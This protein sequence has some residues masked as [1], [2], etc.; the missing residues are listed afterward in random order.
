MQ[1]A[2]PVSRVSSFLPVLTATLV[3]WVVVVWA[4]GRG[5]DFTDDAHYLIWAAN[6]FIY[7]WSVSEFGFLLHPIYRLVEGDI[8]LFRLAG[9][10]LLG[11]GAAVFGYALY[12]FA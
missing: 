12:R 4:M 3:C 6:P 7:D 5:Y 11:G 8:W 1:Q 9:A 10:T 2:E